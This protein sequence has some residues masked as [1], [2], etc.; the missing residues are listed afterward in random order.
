MVM[1]VT[2]SQTTR[3]DCEG[4]RRLVLKIGS[5]T[6]TAGSERISRGKIEDLARQ[7]LAL[8]RDTERPCEVVLVSSG[9]IAAARQFVAVNQWPALD[10]KQ[11]MA[12]VGQPL[13]MQMYH[14]IFRDFGLRTGQCLLTYRDFNNPQARH[15]TQTTLNDLLRNGYLPVVN[16]NDTVAT[17][18]LVFGD[19]DKLSA[20]VAAL[21]QADELILVS[22]VAGLFDSNPHKN[23]QARLIERIGRVADFVH[24]IDERESSLGTGGMTSK[25]QAAEIC[26]RHGIGVRIVNGDENNFLLKVLSGQLAHS[27]FVPGCDRRCDPVA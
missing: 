21:L 2:E 15:N 7:I 1:S 3:R 6:L 4:R 11:A 16:E 12:A 20:Y 13:L 25:L 8:Q 14:E 23:P 24:C 17:D 22:D 18:E 27:H 5:S 10:S 26:L 9:A 19:N